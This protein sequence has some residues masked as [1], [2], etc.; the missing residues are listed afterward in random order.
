MASDLSPLLVDP[1]SLLTIVSRPPPHSFLAQY[2]PITS[3]VILEKLD[4]IIFLNW[5]QFEHAL[6]GQCHLFYRNLAIPTSFQPEDCNLGFIHLA[7]TNCEKQDQLLI[8]DWSHH[9]PLSW[10]CLPWTHWFGPFF[11]PVHSV[12]FVTRL[13]FLL[14]YCR[15]THQGYDKAV[16]ECAEQFQSL[17]ERERLIHCWCSIDF[18]CFSFGPC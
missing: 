1:S 12:T 13:L 7:Y 4:D 11:E 10:V 6:K 8:H 5:K 2:V 16:I 14:H 15:W 17:R 3:F 18:F 9:L